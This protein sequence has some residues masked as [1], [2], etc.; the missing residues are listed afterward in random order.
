MKIVLEGLWGDESIADLYC[1]VSVSQSMYYKCYKEFMEA[2]KQCLLGN[3]KR[4][5]DST[6]VNGPWQTDFNYFKIIDWAGTICSPLRITTPVI[7][8]SGNCHL[9][10]LPKMDTS[11]P[12]MCSRPR[13]W[14]LGPHDKLACI[15][16]CLFDVWPD[17]GIQHFHRSHK[18][19]Y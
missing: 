4:K 1:W 17:R 2:R 18:V 13:V 12:I 5:A 7:S 9:R 15:C 10:W 14:R 19:F 16:Q 11:R 6:E 8:W 3:T